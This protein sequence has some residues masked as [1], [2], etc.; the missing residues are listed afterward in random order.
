LSEELTATDRA[1]IA[2]LVVRFA[3]AVTRN[4]VEQFRS[5][6]ADRATWIID[7]PSNLSQHGTPDDMAQ[8]LSGMPSRWEGFVQL[9]HGT[10]AE[11]ADGGAR[12]RSYVTELARP[13]EGARGYFNHAIYEDMLERTAEGWRFVERHYRY[14]YL[15]DSPVTG[16][17]PYAFGKANPADD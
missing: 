4:D 8:L 14:L 2:E 1:E 7:P 15:D 10:L 13:A 9:V 6:W 5:L 3:D 17:F 16:R 11:A 12:A